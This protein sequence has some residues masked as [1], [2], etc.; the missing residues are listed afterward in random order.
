MSTVLNIPIWTT[1]ADSTQQL[2]FSFP[3]TQTVDASDPSAGD[4]IFATSPVDAADPPLFTIQTFEVQASAGV[5]PTVMT[6]VS[7]RFNPAGILST[8]LL[9]NGMLVSVDDQTN[10]HY[11][12]YDA[13]TGKA[14]DVF[15]FDASFVNSSDFLLLLQS[16]RF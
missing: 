6:A 5:P 10:L 4:Q 3:P 13:V 7:E 14:V 16:L 15:G 9:A 8:S 2:Q 1:F 11:I 12:S